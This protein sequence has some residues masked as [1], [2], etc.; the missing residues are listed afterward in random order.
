MVMIVSASVAEAEFI[1]M[2]SRN[3]RSILTTW[4]GYCR[5]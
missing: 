5:R 1:G 3:E 2:S 4:I